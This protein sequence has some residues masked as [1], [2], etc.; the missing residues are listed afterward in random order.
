MRSTCFVTSFNLFLGAVSNRE[1]QSFSGFPMWLPHFVT[2][3]V[4]IITNTFHMSRRTNGENFVSIQQVVVEKNTN[5]LCGQTYRQTNG[6]KCNTLSFGEDN[7]KKSNQRLQTL[8][9]TSFEWCIFYRFSG[10]C[11]MAAKPCDL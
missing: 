5:V 3:D 1:V 4:I 7:K 6:S 2:Y 9:R 8:A 11:N 10:K